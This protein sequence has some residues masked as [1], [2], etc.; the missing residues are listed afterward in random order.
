[1]AH[2]SSRLGEHKH[3]AT[4]EWGDIVCH[5]R[6]AFLH[7][8]ANQGHTHRVPLHRWLISHRQPGRVPQLVGCFSQS[9]GTRP[10]EDTH[11]EGSLTLMAHLCHTKCWHEANQR[12]PCRVPL[13]WRLISH[14]QLG[15]P[16]MSIRCT[17]VEG[18]IIHSHLVCGFWH[19]TNG[20][21]FA[22]IPSISSVTKLRRPAS[23]SQSHNTTLL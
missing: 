10:T 19:N 15:P 5:S 9:V 20:D 16:F 13:P 12:H 21:A 23:M 17:R 3:T 11:C 4:G 18:V 6:G 1:M 2:L 7:N 22:G 14:K 8:K